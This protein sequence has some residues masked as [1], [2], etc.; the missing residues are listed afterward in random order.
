MANLTDTGTGVLKDTNATWTI[1]GSNTGTLSDLSGSFSGMGTLTDLG[2]GTLKEA[3]ATW[4][5]TGSN[6]GTVTNLSG[7]FNGMANLQDTIAGVFNMGTSGSVSGNLTGVGGMVN[8]GSYATPVTFNLNGGASTGMAGWSG[9]TSVTGSAGSDSIT[10]SGQTYTITGLNN[11]NNGTVFWTSFENLTD[12]TTGTLRATTA[13]WTLNGSNTG[14]VTNLSGTFAGMGNLTDL[15]TA[16]VNMHGTGDGSISGNLNGGT[17]GTMSYAGYTSAV[18]FSLSGAAG[19]T[20]GIGGTRSGITS[21]S[22]SSN[23]DTITGS[24]AT[25][26]LTSQNAGNSSGVTWTSFENITDSSAGTFNLFVASSN[27]TGTLSAASGTLS[28]SQD[29]TALN[30]SIGGTLTVSGTAVNWNLTG[31]PQPSLF[32][33]TNSSA[34]IFFNGACVGGPACGTVL[35]IVGSI[36]STVAQIATQA[37]KDA[38]ST[39]SVA[40]QIDD[41]FAGDVG[42][43]PPMD[44]R[45]DE[46]GISV[47]ECFDESR[48]GAP[49]KN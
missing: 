31:A 3:N 30:L 15:G 48:E 24:G 36:G 23:N 45:I 12:L 17:N 41:G 13:T 25:Y 22:G 8:Y 27:V 19:T 35:T 33:T 21:V 5:V 9:I 46:T 7:S 20:T 43:T 37:L 1:T 16:T 34:N 10:G 11:G 2:S 39:D 4:T 29:I 42:T 14:T 38:Q 47:P 6:A 40:K 44:H 18:T 32:Q 49:C 26:S 28:S